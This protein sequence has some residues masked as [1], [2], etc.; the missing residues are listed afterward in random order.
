MPRPKVT[1]D[2]LCWTRPASNSERSSTNASTEAT[3]VPNE[4]PAQTAASVI[5]AGISAP[6]PSGNSQSR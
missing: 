2:V 5:Q 6:A 3:G 1:L 4:N